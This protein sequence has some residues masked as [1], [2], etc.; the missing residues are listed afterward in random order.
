MNR[1]HQY[2]TVCGVSFAQKGAVG[3]LDDDRLPHY[4]AEMKEEFRRRYEVWRNAFNGLD[5]VT[6]VPPGGAFYIFPD[7]RI[8]DM[9]ARTFCE[10]CLREIRVAIVPGDVFGDRYDRCVRISYGR[11]L[12]TQTEAA[13]RLVEYIRKFV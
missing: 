6:L 10:K 8:P 2:L 7:I 1:I 9:N 5:Y 12:E 4:L 11:N 13:A 3:L